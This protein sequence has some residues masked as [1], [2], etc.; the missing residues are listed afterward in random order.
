[1]LKITRL[2]ERLCV[3]PPLFL[4]RRNIF[5]RLP[6][7]LSEFGRA[8]KSFSRAAPSEAQLMRNDFPK[9]SVDEKINL[10]SCFARRSDPES[11]TR[12]CIENDFIMG[13]KLSN[14]YQ[15]AGVLSA[16][17]DW[18]NKFPLS[19][20]VEI[21]AVKCFECKSARFPSPPP[22]NIINSPPTFGYAQPSMRR[23]F[24]Q[25]A[26]GKRNSLIPPPPAGPEY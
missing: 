15:I 18:P 7:A 17:I 21:C 24:I 16:E 14:Y 11:R 10:I 20:R 6:S 12:L 2:S 22:I 3:F 4:R 1:M 13:K 19:A 25:I 23:L 26:R 5:C 8:E 9:K